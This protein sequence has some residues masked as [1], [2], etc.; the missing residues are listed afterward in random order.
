MIGDLKHRVVLQEAILTPD[1]GGGFTS[2]WQNI[3]TAPEVYA[4]IVPLS[5]SEQLK[6]HQL[7]SIVTHRVTIRHRQDVMPAMRILHGN[8]AYNI[9]SAI[10]RGE[11]GTYLEMLATVRTP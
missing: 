11:P 7:E 3:A 1:G 9:I 6:Y 4:A 5:G 8:T 10:D 2:A